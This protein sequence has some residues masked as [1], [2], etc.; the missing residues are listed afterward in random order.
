MFLSL[1]NFVNW[2]L[3]NIKAAYT[4]PKDLT[5]RFCEEA[6]TTIFQRGELL[7]EGGGYITPQAGR[8]FDILASQFKADP[9]LKP[10]ASLPLKIGQKKLPPKRKP[11]RLLTIH[12][13]G[14]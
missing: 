7:V 3:K 13:Q 6:E 2:G 10:T 5:E 9:S 12:F 8:N 1:G 4:P 14:G 11:D